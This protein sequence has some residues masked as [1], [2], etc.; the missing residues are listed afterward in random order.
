[1]T[2][3]LSLQNGSDVRGTAIAAENDPAA[4]TAEA[5]QAISKAFYALVLDR[6]GLQRACIAIGH[7]PRLSSETIEEAAA[8]AIVSLGGDVILTGLSSTPAMFMLLQDDFGA[9]GSVMITASH[10]PYRKNG[11]KFFL[12]DGGLESSDVKALLKAAGEEDFPP[13]AQK[14][15]IIRRSY[16]A[17]YA[18][19]LCALVRQGTGEMRPLE[20]MKIVLDA[21]N[22]A[23][24]FYDT[25]VLRPLGADTDGSQ[26]LEPDGRFPNHVPNPENEEAMASLT[27]AV[28]RHKADFGIIFDTDVDRAGAVAGNGEE[29][30]RNRLIALISAILLKEEAGG[31]IV[32]DSITSRGLSAFI[33]AHGGVHHRFKRGYRNVI[34]EA[35]RLNAAGIRTPLAIETSGHAALQENFFLDDGAYLVTRLLIELANAK[36]RG[37]KLTDLIKDLQEPAEAVEIRLSFA[38]GTDFK[39][40]GAKVIEELQQKAQRQDGL[41]LAPNNY[42]GVRIDFDKAHGDGWAL[43]RMSLHDPVLPINCESDS[44]GGVDQIRRILYEMMKEYDFLSPE[45][46]L[47]SETK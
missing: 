35:K 12:K 42:E 14:G 33:T 32:T 13:A 16:M 2:D 34:N 36:K 44:I 3:Y 23:G 40:L 17:Q 19:G 9:Q 47:N 8:E 11:M 21:G 27:S 28:K 7:D 31:C 29:I 41:S 38:V 18:N 20:G 6:T 39:A 22:G 45:Q 15:S 10:L 24:G 43:V 30:N 37:E 46:L 26:F 25:L 5:V 1:M 4:L